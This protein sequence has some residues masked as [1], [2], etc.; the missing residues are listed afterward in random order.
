MSKRVFP[1]FFVLFLI[2]FLIHAQSTI[3]PGI[4]GGV[5]LSTFIGTEASEA[6]ALIGPHIGGL[7][8]ITLGEND[9]GF[10]SYALQ[11]ELFYSMQGAKADDGKVTLSYINLPV[12][13]QRYIASSGF[14]IETGPQVGFL[15]SAKSKFEGTSEDIKSQMRSI[16]FALNFG[17]GYKLVS[18]I[19]ISARYSLGATSNANDDSDIHNATISFGLFYVFGGGE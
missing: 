13:I 14:Y 19:G 8:Q 1:F 17:L 2:P 18:G 5:N 10:L 11:P 9:E 15:L 7:A 12:M 4:K 16:D 3:R 6:S